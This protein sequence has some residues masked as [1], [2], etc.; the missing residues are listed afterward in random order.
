M[1]ALGVIPNRN[2]RGASRLYRALHSSLR[3]EATALA[4]LQNLTHGQ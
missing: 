1:S 2:K 4:K 3:E